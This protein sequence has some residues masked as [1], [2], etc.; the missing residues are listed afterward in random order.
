M[1]RPARILY[2]YAVLIVALFVMGFLWIVLY[3]CIQ[4]I[5]AGIASQMVQYDVNGSSYPHYQLADAFMSNLW[6][7]FL[8]IVV[9]GLLY[10]VFI[11]AQRKGQPMVMYE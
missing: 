6:T 7:L 4:P 1:P 2:I 3:A 9:F 10:W 8:V 11:Y 5:Q